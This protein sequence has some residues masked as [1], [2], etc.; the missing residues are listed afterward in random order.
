MERRSGAVCNYFVARSSLSV[1][2]LAGQTLEQGCC[3]RLQAPSWHP[4]P[5][6]PWL[7]RWPVRTSWRFTAVLVVQGRVQEPA[8]MDQGQSALVCA[9]VSLNVECAI[10]TLA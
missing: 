7:G 5:S 4:K 1:S 2:A 9:E 6:H 3:G 10:L 8:V